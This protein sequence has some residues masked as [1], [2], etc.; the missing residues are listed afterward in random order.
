MTVW[1]A[2]RMSAGLAISK[3]GHAIVNVMYMYI[4]KLSCDIFFNLNNTV[5]NVK[6]T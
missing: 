6:N 2:S 1:V 5:L 4:W 3:M